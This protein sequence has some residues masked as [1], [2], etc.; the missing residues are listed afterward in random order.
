MHGMQLSLNA[1]QMT[2]NIH[3]SALTTTSNIL[4]PIPTVYIIQGWPENR[5][6]M[7]HDLRT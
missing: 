2:N 3:G 7:P 4:R 5:Y 1:I 6:Q